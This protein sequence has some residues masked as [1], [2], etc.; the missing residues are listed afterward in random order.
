MENE[1]DI[2]VIKLNN[3]R[4]DQI[5]LTKIL[6]YVQTRKYQFD[7]LNIDVYERVYQQTV[8]IFEDFL[9]NPAQYNMRNQQIRDQINSNFSVETQNLEQ[10]YL[11][12][13]SL[14]GTSNLFDHQ[15]RKNLGQHESNYLRDLKFIK[16]PG[17]N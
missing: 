10:I 5:L 13:T 1:N 4:V 15:S 12:I 3:A 16:D 6:N 2:K 14:Q 7:T 9:L 17:V 11:L 8:Q